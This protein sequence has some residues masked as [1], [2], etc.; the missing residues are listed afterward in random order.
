[1]FYHLDAFPS[2]FVLVLAV[3][4]VL[5]AWETFCF[6]G[7]K[8]DEAVVLNSSGCLERIYVIIPV[9]GGSAE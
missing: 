1:M 9:E 5:R 3:L 2:L 7:Q 6:R 8:G 4:C